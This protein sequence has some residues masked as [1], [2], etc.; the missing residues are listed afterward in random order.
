MGAREGTP[1]EAEPGPDEQESRAVLEPIGGRPARLLAR[2]VVAL[3]W[4][5]LPGWL[6]AAAAA[7]I[8][9]PSVTEGSAATLG[10]L[11]PAHSR[12]VATEE[13]ALRLFRVP[14]LAQT[15]IVQRDPRGL[16]HAAQL[17]V[18][19][20]ALRIDR[21]RSP[22]L[23]SISLALPVTNFRGAFPSARERGTTA[24]TYLFFRRDATISAQNAL[25]HTYARVYVN[26]PGDALVGVTG[27]VPARHEQFQAIKR[28]LPIIEISTVA[29]IALILGL[30]FRAIGAPLA[31]LFVA[32]I[33]F[34]LDERVLG[35][36]SEKAGLTIPREVKPVTVAL[37]LGIVTDYAVFFFAGARRRLVEGEPRVEVAR[38][39][40]AEYG[41]IVL[42]AGLVVAA[43]TATLVFGTL[44]FFRSFGPGM[45]I[46]VLTGLAVSVTALPALLAIFGRLLFWPGS[47]RPE[48]P[49]RIRQR[50]RRERLARVLAGRPVAVLI[51]L[52]ALAA[53]VVPT[54]GVTG[55]ALGFRLIH[56]LDPSS[57][58]VRAARAAAAGF[59]PGILAPVEVVL[60]H[61]GLARRRPALGRLQAALTREH[62][63]AGVVGPGTPRALQVRGAT[64]ARSGNAARY[65]V[66]L[67]VDPQSSRGIRRV[68]A[69]E[70]HLPSLL[71]GS[72]LPAVRAGFAGESALAAETVDSVTTSMKRIAV[73][74]FLVNLV[75]LAIFLQ[76]LLAPL[77]LLV[78]SA[79]GLTASLGLTTLV[80]Q[81]W[82]GQGDLTYYVPL[83]A[84]VLLV[85][86]GSDYNLFVVGRIW[87]EARRRPLREAIA[88]AA[89]RASRAIRI[90]GLA[91]AVS[92]ALLAI[93]PLD[94]FR[95]FAFAMAAGVLIDTFLVRAVLV[96]ALI[97]LFGG[98]SWWPRPR[99]AAPPAPM[100][101]EG[102]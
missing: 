70:M 41:P 67:D 35:W 7:A 31:T 98:A 1:P 102:E 27:A 16:S 14:L 96:P 2:A 75:L 63:V 84:G 5:I 99:P 65:L 17:R 60:E 56:S 101:E 94:E 64:I 42:T 15:V 18:G 22:L 40:T 47:R 49:A 6:A 59:A 57:E 44:S 90:A 26:R 76:A 89:P 62:G 74:A 83:A 58:P 72:G 79:L 36:V 95:T 25:A 43:G 93:V 37:L 39:T 54:G 71:R 73:A 10:D 9:L 55:T 85:S 12:A 53:L 87:L 91:L 3:R 61:P 24:L 100:P 68:K 38:R 30:S 46:T 97:A 69:L 28:A 80:F 78:A 92:F 51:A 19:R 52:A 48:A 8:Y 88:V 86:L 77:Y 11:L 81:R 82:Q 66:V 50:V 13:R 33:A 32:G 23:R 34:V 45:A 4:L 29:L 20:R 21:H